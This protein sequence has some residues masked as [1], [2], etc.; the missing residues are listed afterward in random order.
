MQVNLLY[1]PSQTVAQCWIGAGESVMGES[2]AMIGMTPNVQMQTQSGGIMKGLGRM[3]LGGESFFRNTFTAVGS[4][5][6]VLFAP[7]LCGDVTVI[8]V[9]NTPWCVSN[10]GYIASAPTVDVSPRLD[11]GGFFSGSGL[12]VLSATGRGPLILGSYGALEAVQ[13]D[14]T[15]LVD[16]GHIAAWE[17]SLQ[18]ELVKSGSGWI[19]SFLSGEGF[20]CRFRGRGTLWLQTRN[21]TEF[22]KSVGRLLPAREG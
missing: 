13:I 7:P 17:G 14:G 10:S 4:T 2:G 15:F 9:G 22:G 18:Y 5:G 21:P 19:S 20:A 16:T 12:F 8:D 11:F 1:R 3:L 6:E